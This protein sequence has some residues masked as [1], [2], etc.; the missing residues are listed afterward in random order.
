M[1]SAPDKNDRL[2]RM[3]LEYGGKAYRHV[4]DQLGKALYDTY[5]EIWHYHGVY[6]LIL[7]SNGRHYLDLKNPS[8]TLLV[9]KNSLILINPFVSHRIRMFEGESFEHTTILWR[10]RSANGRILRIPIQSFLYQNTAVPECE[11]VTLNDTEAHD[12][13]Q[14]VERLTKDCGQM[15]E[16]DFWEIPFFHFWYNSLRFFNKSSS[17]NSQEDYWIIRINNLLQ[18]NF[19]NHGYSLGILAEELDR[20]PNYL[21]SLYRRKCGFS[22]GDELNRLR[23]Q[24]AAQMLAETEIPVNEVAIKSGCRPGGRFAEKFRHYS[25]FLP[26]QYR[27]QSLRRY[28]TVSFREEVFQETSGIFPGSSDQEK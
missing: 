18:R 7:V 28:G 2:P 4:L 8:R 13:K 19:R 25:G 15:Q 14:D 1:Q 17:E 23:M 24:H 22:I 5:D 6:H 11:I 10:L 20:H 16:N 21:G 27:R 26:L 12:F 9:E 3:S